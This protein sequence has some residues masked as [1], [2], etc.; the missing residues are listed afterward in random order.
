[1]VTALSDVANRLR[2]LEVGAD[3]FLTKPVNDIAL[4]ARVRSLARLKRMMEEWRL[5][6]EICGR[7]A[8]RDIAAN[9]DAGPATI[10]IVEEDRFA[11]A[12]MAETLRSVGH[13]VTCAAGGAEAQTLL[14][15]DTELIILSLSM[16]SCDPL[17][18]VSQ[19]R[20][21]E[22]FR[23]LPILL[24]AED[25]DLIRVAKGLVDL[26]ANDYLIKPVDRNELLARTATQV[27]RKRLQ[28]RLQQNY[29]RGLSLA[30]TDPLTNLYVRRYGEA[31]LDEL[32]GRV[33]QDVASA[34]VLLFDVDHFKQ[35]NDTH[36]HDAGDD[37]LRELAARTIKSVR[38]VDLAVRWGGEEFLVVMPETDLANAAAV[39][40]RLRAA[41]AKDWFTVRSSGEK[42]AVTI[43]VGVAAAIPGDDHRDQ[44][45]KRADD[46][47]YSAK[48]TGR[49]RVVIRSV[50]R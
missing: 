38:S 17:R 41:V 16:P 27:R 43:S 14:D 2:G 30:L 28:D 32:M 4:F 12:Q 10:L 23:Q 26:G 44:L 25:I 37:V 48:L 7:F 1:M 19:C 34:A 50:D 20:A 9:G 21:N 15:G 35:V 31:H 42:L 6:E 8:G 3:D 22:A 47:L 36:G 33:N 24:I 40:E 11:A 18:L 29:Q 49:N 45:L 39:A 13:S 5:R 46:A